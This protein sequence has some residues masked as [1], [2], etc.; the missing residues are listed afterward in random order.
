M[1]VEHSSN[2]RGISEPP[3]NIRKFDESTLSTYRADRDFQYRVE[4]RKDG[5]TCLDRLLQYLIYYFIRSMSFLTGTVPGKIIFYGLCLA[6]II[7]AVTRLF[8]ID[9]K[10][11]FFNARK[12]KAASI[13]IFEEDIHEISFEERIE[14]AYQKKQ[15][16]ECVRLTFLFSLKKLSD[17]NLIAW[18]AGKTNDDYLR[19]LSQHPS[20]GA[21]QELRLYFDYSWY[22]HF[23]VDENIYQNIRKVFTDFSQKIS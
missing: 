18:K 11:M 2:V 15:Y 19:E 21:L 22:G 16:R 3:T 10:E 7:F 20:S 13:A 5:E 14:D 4:Q 17:Q 8:N 23:E 6:I 12:T 1:V 9:V